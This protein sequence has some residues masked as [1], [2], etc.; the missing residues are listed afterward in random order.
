MWD[1]FTSD[2]HLPLPHGASLTDTVTYWFIVCV[3]VCVWE[4]DTDLSFYVSDPDLP[5]KLI[6]LDEVA[7][8]TRLLKMIGLFCKR[9]LEKRLYSAKET[10]HFKEP[11]N[12]SHPIP[13]GE[14]RTDTVRYWFIVC[15]CV[16]VCVCD[17]D[18]PFHVRDT[19]LPLILIYLYHMVYQ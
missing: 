18:L 6:Y 8:I 9:A 3:C 11:T 16:C 17:T 7:T 12:R 15:V 13:H 19:D 2:T 4:C 10:Y 14:S 5:L 1:W